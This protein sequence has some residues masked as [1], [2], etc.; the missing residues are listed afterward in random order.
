MIFKRYTSDVSKSI[1]AMAKDLY[2]YGSITKE[3]LKKYE[4]DCFAPLFPAKPKVSA[5]LPVPAGKEV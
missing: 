3:Q 5:Y 4:K 2:K 1:Y